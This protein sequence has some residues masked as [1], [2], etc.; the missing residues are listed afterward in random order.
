MLFTGAVP[1]A[2]KRMFIASS[3]V[4]MGMFVSPFCFIWK[5]QK[6]LNLRFTGQ[7]RGFLPLNY[8]PLIKNKEGLCPPL[9]I[10]ILF[11]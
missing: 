1:I 11:L 5:G 4:V 10:L 9:F 7:S 2:A 3:S 8:V 6:D